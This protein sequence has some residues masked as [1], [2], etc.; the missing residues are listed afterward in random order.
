MARTVVIHLSENEYALLLEQARRKGQTAEEYLMQSV[1]SILSSKEPVLT[2]YKRM[3]PQER[4]QHL[5]NLFQK[6]DAYLRSRQICVAGDSS[7]LIR[8]LREENEGSS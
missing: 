1:K 7:E 4:R 8:E 3:S 2:R 5:E 6:L